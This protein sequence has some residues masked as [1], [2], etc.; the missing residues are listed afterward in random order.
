MA[1]YG[2]VELSPRKEECPHILRRGYKDESM[3]F[4]EMNGKVCLLVSG[5]TCDTW[6]EIQGDWAEEA[7]ESK[8]KEEG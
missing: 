7:E 6:E 4:C 1:T 5:D 3:D 8:A 2:Y